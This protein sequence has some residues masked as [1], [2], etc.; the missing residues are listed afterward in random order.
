MGDG[1]VAVGVG[2]GGVA[3]GMGD[4]GVAVGVGDGGV[5]VGVG[6][7]GV[8]VGMGDGGVAVGMG[9]G[10][11]AVGGGVGVGAGV[12]VV[13]TEACNGAEGVGFEASS[14]PSSQASVAIA[15]NAENTHR[16]YVFTLRNRKFGIPSLL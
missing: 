9:D 15:S 11:V 6:D 2:D 1:G 13:G 16:V 14:A 7:G 12:P 4:G 3:V 8:A 5:A 10:G